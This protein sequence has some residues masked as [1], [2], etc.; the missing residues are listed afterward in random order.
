MRKDLALFCISKRTGVEC[1]YLSTNRFSMNWRNENLTSIFSFQFPRLRKL[2]ISNFN[3]QST[4]KTKIRIWYQFSIFTENG[5]WNSEANFH[6]SIRPSS[7]YLQSVVLTS[8][9]SENAWHKE[10]KPIYVNIKET[11]C[12]LFCGGIQA[13]CP[14]DWRAQKLM[15]VKLS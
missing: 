10:R 3:L 1:V 2:K 13:I 5:N 9:K 15:A 11:V 8:D 4:R 7:F 6:I 14:V 12:G